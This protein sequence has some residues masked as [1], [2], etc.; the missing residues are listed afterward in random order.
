MLITEA[1][2]LY[3]MLKKGRWQL[4]HSSYDLFAGE[5]ASWSGK[6]RKPEK[7]AV[8]LAEAIDWMRQTAKQTSDDSGSTCV[9]KEGRLVTL[10]WTRREKGMRILA[11]GPSYLEKKWLAPLAPLAGKLQ[12][13]FSLKEMNPEAAAPTVRISYATGLPWTVLIA[14]TDV[15]S[16]VNAY[17]GRRNLLLGIFAL[18]LVVIAAGS[19][20]VA[21]AIAREFAV[22]RLQSEFVSAVSHEFRTPLTSLRQLSE[23][24]NEGRPLGEERRRD[25]YQ[26]LDRATHRLQKLVEGLLDFGRMEAKAMVYRKRDLDAGALLTS[27]VNDFQ[28]EAAHNGYH[29]E[30]KAAQDI[31]EVHADPEALGNAIW[32]LLDNA[33]KYSPEC[34]TIRAEADRDGMLVAIRVK[35]QGLG[36]PAAE[37]SK[38]T[39]KFVR[40]SAA[41]TMGIKG[42][43]VGLAMVKHIVDAHGGTLRIESAPGEGSTFTILLPAR[44]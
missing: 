11:A 34:K 23:V 10:L 32:N 19:Y 29:I 44:R 7:A 24:L 5:A 33:V 22:M 35:D 42:T 17:A 36:V 6:S 31:P 15:Q 1:A 28:R 43:G 27:V 12:V 8:A 37:H 25:Y 20:T 41:E 3:D 4:S 30:V 38:I 39:R 9:T 26:A 21:R 13:K 2:E 40:G 16:E 14:N 18:L